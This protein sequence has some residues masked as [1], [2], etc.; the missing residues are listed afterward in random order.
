MIDQSLTHNDL[1]NL[2]NRYTEL[3]KRETNLK[4]LHLI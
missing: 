3:V 2:K 4:S 1:V